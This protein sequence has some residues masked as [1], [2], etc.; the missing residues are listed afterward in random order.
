M[1]KTDNDHIS[2]TS[3][4]AKQRFLGHATVQSTEV[5]LRRDVTDLRPAVDARQYL[6][7]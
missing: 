4:E 7:L 6:F 3:D 1:P 5:Y 2:I